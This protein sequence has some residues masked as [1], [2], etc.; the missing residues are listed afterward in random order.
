MDLNSKYG[1]IVNM[2]DYGAMWPVFIPLIV[3]LGP[4]LIYWLA[5]TA[6]RTGK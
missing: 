2:A 1:A 5:I 6:R 4:G 3:G